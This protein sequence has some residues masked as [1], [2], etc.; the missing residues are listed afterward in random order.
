MYEKNGSTI[1][2]QP[3]STIIIITHTICGSHGV[4]QF[5]SL[6]DMEL[7]V[8]YSQQNQSL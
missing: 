3:A 4:L 1:S 8:F 6:L 5:S 7:V 2:M